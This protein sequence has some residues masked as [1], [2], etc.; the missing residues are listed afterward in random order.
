MFSLPRAGRVLR[1]RMKPRSDEGMKEERARTTYQ[2]R[3]CG[4]TAGLG[5]GRGLEGLRRGTREGGRIND[6]KMEEAVIMIWLMFSL[7]LSAPHVP[8]SITA[9]PKKGRPR[10]RCKYNT[11]FQHHNLGGNL[12]S[13]PKSY[14][15]M[16]VMISGLGKSVWNKL[17][18]ASCN[19]DNK[20]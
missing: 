5:G 11:H 4:R 9:F 18:L 3:N 17:D 19:L 15:L 1:W 14:D 6:A 7:S 20:E 2:G 8:T 16:K 12:A 10:P 13:S